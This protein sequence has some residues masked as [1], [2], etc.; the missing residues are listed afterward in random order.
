MK[1]LGRLEGRSVGSLLARHGRLIVLEEP[2]IV[3]PDLPVIKRRTPGDAIQPRP[4][5]PR[6]AQPAKSRQDAEPR[7]LQ[8]V[9]GVLLPVD[10]A[11][12][13]VEQSPFPRADQFLQGGRLAAP[14]A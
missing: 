14:A 9:P 3:R 8:H 7:L 6:L 1:L 13:E 12:D 10:E 4:Q 2:T 11:A 5:T